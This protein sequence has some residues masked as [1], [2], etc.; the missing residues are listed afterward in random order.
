M[1]EWRRSGQIPAFGNWD[2]ANELPITQYFESARQ[3]GLIRFS[4]TH[5]S[6]GECGHQDMRGDLYASDI[7]KPSRNLPPPVKTRM[8][9]KRGTHGKE[10]RKQGKVCDVTEPAKKQ[11]QQPQPTVY[12]KNKISQYSQKMDTVIVA[13]APVKPPKAIDEDLYKISPE[14]LRSSKR[15]SLLL[16]LLEY[17]RICSNAVCAVPRLVKMGE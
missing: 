10:Q 15:V 8:R 14:L 5:N 2:Q 9:E 13:K 1:D 17:T 7:S 6:S 3:A 16:F 12:H 4:T 11:Q